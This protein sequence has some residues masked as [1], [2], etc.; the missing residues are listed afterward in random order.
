MSGISSIA[1]H[2]AFA[3][4]QLQHAQQTK[5]AAAPTVSDPDHDGDTDT[6]GVDKGGKFNILA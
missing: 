4:A 2:A 3:P 1:A 5:A 6:G